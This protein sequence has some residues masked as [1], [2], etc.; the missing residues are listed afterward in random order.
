M[1][2]LA[3]SLT[4][5]LHPVATRPQPVRVWRADSILHVSLREPGH[6]LLLHVDAIGRVR[7]LLPAAPSDNSANADTSF[8]LT[9]PPTAQGNPATFLVVRSRWG[10][11][12]SDLRSG[13]AWDY[14]NAWLLQPTA[15]DPIAALL[16]IADRVTDGRP[17]DYGVASY[18]RNGTLTARQTPLQP[19]VCLSCVRQGTAVAAT[20]AAAQN[21]NVDCSNASL[22]NAFCGVANG[23]VSITSEVAYEPPA[24]QAAPAPVA[25]Y[26]PYFVPFFAHERFGRRERLPVQAPA[27]MRMQGAAYPIAPRLVVPSAG[28]LRTF[29]GRRH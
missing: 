8:T 27:P 28:E 7:V 16:E 1:L 11:D 26:V 4:L 23:N 13:P 21:N 17:Y 25:V 5:V 3:L 14:D 20:P 19:D 10:F 6:I 12:F 9:L 15:G 22:T 29:G 24:E 18:L 2:A